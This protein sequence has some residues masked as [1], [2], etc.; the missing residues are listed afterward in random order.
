MASRIQEKGT[1][2]YDI[3]DTGD[4]ELLPHGFVIQT[5]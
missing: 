2:H 3:K 1:I 4:D 5:E